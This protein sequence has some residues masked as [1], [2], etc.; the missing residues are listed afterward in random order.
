[1][2]IFTV[3]GANNAA[4]LQ[5]AVER[6]FRG[7]FLQ[8]GPGQWLLAAEGKTARQVTDELGISDGTNGN[9]IVTTVGNYWGRHPNDTWEWLKVKM[10]STGG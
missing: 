9:A 1:M 6:K 3:F 4:A 8:V 7:N 5:S 2:A 10:E